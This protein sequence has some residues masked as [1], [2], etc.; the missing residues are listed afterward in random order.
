MGD[1]W[2]TATKYKRPGL[3]EGLPLSEAEARPDEIEQKN[4]GS[5][6]EEKVKKF[7]KQPGNEY[8]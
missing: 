7:I 3:L 4:T 2:L 6:S 5:D 1:A 8:F